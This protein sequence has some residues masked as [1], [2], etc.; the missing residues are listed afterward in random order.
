MARNKAV[1]VACS[2][3]LYEKISAYRVE[4]NLASDA[5]AMR[6]L[7]LFALRILEHSDS[8][9]EVST[10]ELLES[11]LKYTVKDFYQGSMVYYQTFDENAIA[12]DLSLQRSHRKANQDKAELKIGD[13]LTGKDKED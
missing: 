8:G 9:E 5:E 7:T 6:E 1:Q 2:P 3:N 13:I 11:I 12:G 10:R 4:K